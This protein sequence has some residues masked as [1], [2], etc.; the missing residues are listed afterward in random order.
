[1]SSQS[2]ALPIHAV[3][4]LLLGLV[5]ACSVSDRRS[6]T[7]T[8]PSAAEGSLE[9]SAS[10]TEESVLSQM[11]LLHALVRSARRV[12]LS[13]KLRDGIQ[14][15][16]VRIWVRAANANPWLHAYAA[17]ADC[18]KDP[19]GTRFRF[20]PRD[21]ANPTQSYV[22]T[23][24]GPDRRFGT[25]DDWIDDVEDASKRRAKKPSG[26]SM[27]K[28]PW[29]SPEDLIRAVGSDYWEAFLPIDHDGEHW[30]YPVWCY[31]LPAKKGATKEPWVFVFEAKRKI[32]YFSSDGMK[33]SAPSPR[34]I[35]WARR[36][37]PADAVRL[38]LSRRV[39][40]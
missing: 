36:K 3:P 5:A 16:Y 1:M 17:R 20:E 2:S 8:R 11:Q 34:L 38:V 14:D 28:T 9:S 23:S 40:H 19:W 37:N 4:L 24:A 32:R 13:K 27:S 7:M 18:E 22:L 35:G 26:R 12:P 39:K 21:K 30:V 15:P 31:E 29:G 33:R 6:L 10:P 25:A